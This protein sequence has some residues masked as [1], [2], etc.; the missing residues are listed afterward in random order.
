MMHEC[1]QYGTVADD[2]DNY[3][4]SINTNN[5]EEEEFLCH[6]N[7]F[8]QTALHLAVRQD[9]Q[10]LIT[11]YTERQICLNIGNNDGD[12]PLHYAAA[13]GRYEAAKLLVD[14]GAKVDIR[15]LKGELP[16]DDAVK[17]QYDNIISLL[18]G[19]TT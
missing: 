14:A 8:G 1:W 9:L 6:R 16:L 3:C 13:H 7:D 19:G 10:E 12:T 5:K 11:V 4:K 18:D 17:G 2:D 15:N